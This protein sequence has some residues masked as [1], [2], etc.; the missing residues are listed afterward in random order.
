MA[1]AGYTKT[2]L[3]YDLVQGAFLDEPVTIYSLL[4]TDGVGYELSK[5]KCEILELTEIDFFKMV[6][7]HRQKQAEFQKKKEIRESILVPGKDF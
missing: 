6:E 4:L 3:K 7:E 2:V 5:T 1:V